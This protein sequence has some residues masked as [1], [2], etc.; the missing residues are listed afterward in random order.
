ML[1]LRHATAVHS[2]EFGMAVY[3]SAAAR[4]LGL[5]HVITLYRPLIRPDGRIKRAIVRNRVTLRQRINGVKEQTKRGS[6][7]PC[8]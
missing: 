7:T 1:R 2:H 3:G 8:P 4:W 5:P 6:M